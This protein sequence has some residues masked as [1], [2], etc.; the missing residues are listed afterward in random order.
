M[1]M[2]LIYVIPFHTSVTVVDITE[3]PFRGMRSCGHSGFFNFCHYKVSQH[4]ADRRAHG[5]SEDFSGMDV[6][7][8]EI[9][10]IEEKI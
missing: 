4:G 8:F 5:T 7:V 10:V 2:K 9:I 1:K 6:I 3:P